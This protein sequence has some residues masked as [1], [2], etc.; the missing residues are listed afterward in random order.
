MKPHPHPHGRLKKIWSEQLQLRRELSLTC[1]R[2]ETTPANRRNRVRWRL[3]LKSGCSKSG[4]T[5]ALLDA[6]HLVHAA[7]LLITPLM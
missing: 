5:L 2:W 6:V 4:A 1:R 3:V 7:P